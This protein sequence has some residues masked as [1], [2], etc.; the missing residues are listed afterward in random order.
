[1][2]QYLAELN[3]TQQKE[4]A[5]KNLEAFLDGVKYGSKVFD[6]IFYI[7]EKNNDFCIYFYKYKSVEDIIKDNSGKYQEYLGSVDT[8]SVYDE[9]GNPIKI[10]FFIGQ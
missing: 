9:K 4:H 7:N 1:M 3:H 5:L 6:L 8:N 2:Q 10:S